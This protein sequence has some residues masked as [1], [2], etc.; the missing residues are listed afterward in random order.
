MWKTRAGALRGRGS[1]QSEH[2]V[3]HFRAASPNFRWKWQRAR[4]SIRAGGRDP[5]CLPPR[6]PPPP[7]PPCP[8]PRGDGAPE[9]AETV[10]V[11]LAESEEAAAQALSAAAMTVS[12][13][14]ERLLVIAVT[15]VGLSERRNTRFRRSSVVALAR[16]RWSSRPNSAGRLSPASLVARNMS[17]FA[18]RGGSNVLHSRLR[19]SRVR[20]GP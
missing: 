14:A 16:R 7:H 19:R 6:L 13:S 9:I 3:A 15:I 2:S 20:V 18:S 10:A 12:K 1:F 4:F 17:S 5:R 8:P 11:W